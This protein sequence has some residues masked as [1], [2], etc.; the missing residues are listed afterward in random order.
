VPEHEYMSAL[1]ELVR[2]GSFKHANKTTKMFAHMF[3]TTMEKAGVL[4][5]NKDIVTDLL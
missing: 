1:E 3:R 4:N 5:A 2:G